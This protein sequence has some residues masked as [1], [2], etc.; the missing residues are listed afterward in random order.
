[1]KK[2]AIEKNYMI[3]EFFSLFEIKKIE[4]VIEKLKNYHKIKIK[5]ALKVRRKDKLKEDD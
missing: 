5:I 4:Q 2:N 3:M 1:M